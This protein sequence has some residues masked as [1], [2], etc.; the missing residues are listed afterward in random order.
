[1]VAT[2]KLSL[3]DK[4]ARMRQNDPLPVD[5][6]LLAKVVVQGSFS[7][8]LNA[9]DLQRL[10]TIVKSVHMKHY[11]QEMLNDYEA[12]RIIDVLA[13]ETREYLIRKAVEKGMN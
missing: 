5:D 2:N 11:P 12:D 13:P 9:K 3:K 7:S 8:S 4:I 6:E 1:M 10:R